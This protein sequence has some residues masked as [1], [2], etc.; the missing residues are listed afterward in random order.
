M[1]RKEKN[2]KIDS[3]IVVAIITGIFLVLGAYINGCFSSKAAKNDLT[4]KT[5]IDTVISNN[6]VVNQTPHQSNNTNSS[7]YNSGRDIIISQPQPPIPKAKKENTA[8]QANDAPVIINENKGIV[9]NGGTGNTYNQTLNQGNTQRTLEDKEVKELLSYIDRSVPRK[10]RF[11]VETT[12]GD[13]ETFTL[14]KMVDKRLNELGFKIP[15][16]KVSMFL[17]FDKKRVFLDKQDD[18][19]LLF[20]IQPQSQ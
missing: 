20:V 10:F 11:V 4:S 1:I 15:A 7:Q 2:K 18:S 9:N 12:Q 8:K 5:N 17:D 3:A 13:N 6:T 14:G 19:T 16:Y